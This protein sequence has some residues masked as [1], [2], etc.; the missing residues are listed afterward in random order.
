MQSQR[1]SNV[2]GEETAGKPPQE[3]PSP[4]KLRC[5]Q[6]ILDIVCSLTDREWR[7]LSEDVPHAGTKVQFASLCTKII[8]S[9]SKSAV[10][11]YL[12]SLLH[13]V[14]MEAVL[15]A[16][17]KL[18]KK[19][20]CASINPSGSN[21]A[22]EN[23][24]KRSPVEP[25][26]LICHIVEDF[27]SEVKMAMKQSICKVASCEESSWSKD[28]KTTCSLV[29]K[30][31]MTILEGK[32]RHSQPQDTKDLR[33]KQH[34][35]KTDTEALT[36]K[37]IVVVL[38]V[39]EGNSAERTDHKT[40]DLL[41]ATAERL[42]QTATTS[43]VEERMFVDY[44]KQKIHLPPEELQTK[45]ARAVSQL[46]LSST[47][48]W[49]MSSSSPEM[50]SSLASETDLDP[51]LE[52]MARSGFP[53]DLMQSH[54]DATSR[55]IVNTIQG[56]IDTFTSTSP[57]MKIRKFHRPLS[58]D[59]AK[60]S[61]M[62]NIFHRINEKVKMFFGVS[63][64]FVKKS[65][66]L[67]QNTV[68]SSSAS[69][70]SLIDHLIISCTNDVIGG[71]THLY[72]PD[73]LSSDSHR[74]TGGKTSQ[75]SMASK[76][77]VHRV[78]QELEQMISAS[79]S[80]STWSLECNYLESKNNSSLNSL[81]VTEMGRSSSSS[82]QHIE[83]LF[84][85]KFQEKATQVV[86][87]ALLK[88][89]GK[90]S[91]AVSVHS[92]KEGSD[93]V[94][95][96]EVDMPESQPVSSFS[97][98]VLVESAAS[99]ITNT[100]L[101]GL[102]KIS[103]DQVD[104]ESLAEPAPSPKTFRSA[105]RRL[106]RN[107][108]YKVNGFLLR[109]QESQSRTESLLSS[110]EFESNNQTLKP[111]ESS[112]SDIVKSRV[113]ELE[114]ESVLSIRS[115]PHR[116]SARI[117]INLDSCTDEIFGKVVELYKSELRLSTSSEVPLHISASLPEQLVRQ[118]SVEPKSFLDDLLMPAD[119]Q[120]ISHKCISTEENDNI[121]ERIQAT[122]TTS[123]HSMSTVP[124]KTPSSS[125][126]TVSE[127]TA[128]PE[129]DIIQKSD[130][131]AETVAVLQPLSLQQTNQPQ[132]LTSDEIIRCHAER[133][134]SFEVL[135]CINGRPCL[136]K[137]SSDSVL[138]TS[139]VRNNLRDPVQ[140]P[141][142]LVY[143]FVDESVKTLLKHLLSLN[144]RSS[145]VADPSSTSA[146]SKGQDRL[147]D[148]S[149]GSQCESHLSKVLTD[150]Q[151]RTEDPLLL[152]V[153]PEQ[154]DRNQDICLSDIKSPAVPPTTSSRAG[155]TMV[156]ETL[157]NHIT[158]SQDYETYS[159]S[160][161]LL[162]DHRLSDPNPV[163]VKKSKRGFR[164]IVCRKAPLFSPGKKSSK[165]FPVDMM[166]DHHQSTSSSGNLQKAEQR[167]SAFRK[168]CK[169]LSRIF[170]AI[171]KALPNPFQCLTPQS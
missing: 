37:I 108:Q 141:S 164:F 112:S 5:F 22:E 125:P 113:E 16:E 14:G 152:L 86:S 53:T 142:S 19:A 21:T 144:P 82:R 154:P 153:D 150:S 63:K 4:Q 100:F 66:E 111:A 45:A 48:V 88:T 168:T 26:D 33:E 134:T 132:H 124:R 157:D 129:Y 138:D 44:E 77:R 148:K 83:S 171:R 74:S 76:L 32:M 95:T 97:S 34:A 101:N 79:R 18:R 59:T 31:M 69:Q 2:A 104:N 25:S 15:M 123:H 128:D 51:M 120:R 3:P 159:S 140:V 30:E 167:E 162:N 27:V 62:H 6:D 114:S 68:P 130:S 143:V 156:K 155:S 147:S 13:V 42:I 38:D 24:D 117:Q 12:P 109:L 80:S 75:M 84:N 70:T 50:P 119:R 93:G 102:R 8:L 71:I 98:S 7:T 135:R 115:P 160:S 163:A 58:S 36:G 116:T 118:I 90:M 72:H 136:R 85:G 67:Q 35:S 169:H 65:T 165:I 139:W 170:T 106:Y 49:D 78:T 105:A 166:S 20:E 94:I 54:L 57:S 55:D 133:L 39:L 10:Q 9:V 56:S 87:D 91:T 52:A 1:R 131:A 43:E 127:R 23:S 121:S 60:D 17:E 47:G 103:S 145:H 149:A 158:S 137:H 29:A 28:W 107:V 64:Q 96:K 81:T 73:D 46:L 89:C 11:S 61:M 92:S 110:T 146:G 161:S 151:S 40:S 126:F 99:D 122:P 41:R